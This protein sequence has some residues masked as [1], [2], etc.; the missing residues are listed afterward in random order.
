MRGQ[1]VA[2]F[3]NRL[4]KRVTKSFAPKM[5]AHAFHQPLPQ[6][7]AA[8]LVDCSVTN[9]RELMRARRDENEDGVSLRQFMQ[10][11]AMKSFLRRSQRIDM[12]LA[13][14]NKNADL[15]GRF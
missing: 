5:F 8:F 4:D 10:P 2:D 6:L 13:A 1:R 12:Q 3:V 9:D 11:K 15:A 7:F 14:L